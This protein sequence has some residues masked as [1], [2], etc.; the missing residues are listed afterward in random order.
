MCHKRGTTHGR[1]VT[2]CSHGTRLMLR[3]LFHAVL[4][5][6]PRTWSRAPLVRYCSC[7]A[8][9]M[10]GSKP[11]SECPGLLEEHAWLKK[12]AS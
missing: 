8:Y 12:V 4:Y 7:G 3:R 5:G 10:N 6:F 11:S 9:A 1:N 2:C